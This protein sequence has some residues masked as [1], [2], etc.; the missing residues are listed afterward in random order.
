MLW[1]SLSDAGLEAVLGIQFDGPGEVVEAILCAA[2]DG[3]E[4]RQAVVGVVGLGIVERML[5][6]WSAASS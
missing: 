2:G 5:L 1:K 4:Q 3:V 6:N